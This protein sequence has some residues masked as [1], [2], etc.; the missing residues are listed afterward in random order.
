MA[1]SSDRR[2]VAEFDPW[3]I[4]V[5]DNPF[6]YWAAL[7]EHAPVHY[8]ERRKLWIMSRFADIAAAVK[9]VE[10]FSSEMVYVG[11]PIEPPPLEELE[12]A[13]VPQPPAPEFPENPPSE[14]ITDEPVVLMSSVA[15]IDPPEHTR[16]R[17]LVARPLSA[18]IIAELE[19]PIRKVVDELIDGMVDMV[20]QEG[21]ADL[22]TQ[23]AYPLTLRVTGLLM[24]VPEYEVARL[25]RLARESL[26]HFSLDPVMRRAVEGAY[27]PYAQYFSSSY[28]ERVAT[29]GSDIKRNLMAS[30][31]RPDE[32]GE[33]LTPDEFAA[34]SATLF[35]AGFETT[36]SML[37]NGVVT[38]LNHPE[39]FAAL[40]E[41]P[42]LIPN[43]IEEILRF[44]SPITGLLRILR[45][46]AEVGGA[47]VPT[48]SF[49]QLL[50]ASGNR[51]PEHFDDPDTFDITRKNAK[52][53]L[54]FGGV[55]RHVCVGANLARLEGRLAF[56]RLLERTRDLKLAGP[57]PISRSA[58]LRGHTMVPVTFQAV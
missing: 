5:A 27:V 34:N 10:T 12:A 45:K 8:V 47:T 52:E 9:D 19:E 48:G 37:G 46:D 21:A 44:S 7:R 4:D 13:W 49:I 55:S 39:Q 32:S 11:N 40:R 28:G 24:D 17:A 30:M 1:E 42:T 22:H 41:Q 2:L 53:H 58:I 15:E 57:A 14:G 38:L 56:E 16:L 26:G 6:P 3:A 43:A 54:S 20:R 25:G 31:L 18:A 33:R 36:T 50:F 23:F 51:D 29:S 35:R